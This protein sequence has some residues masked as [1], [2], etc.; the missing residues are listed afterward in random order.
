MADNVSPLFGDYTAKIN[1][2]YTTTPYRGLIH[3]ADNVV[4]EPGCVGGN[5][6]PSYNASLVMN[7]TLAADLVIVCLGV[8]YQ[9]EEEDTDRPNLGLPGMQ[10]KLL[11]DVITYTKRPVIVLVF[12][13]GPV[14]LS[15]PKYSP[16]VGALIQCF[17]PAQAT[18]E[19]LLQVLFTRPPE[20]GGARGGSRG[21][22][23]MATSPA[24]RSP[25]TWPLNLTQ[26]PEMTNYSMEGR[27]YRYFAGPGAPLYPFGYGLSYSS[28]KYSDLVIS[29]LAVK[30]GDN[31]SV[32]VNIYNLGPY[33]SD[34]VT[35]VYVSWRNAPVRMP[36]IQLVA[37]ARTLVEY[38]PASQ[39]YPL[40]LS[41]SADQLKVWDDSRGF[42]FY[43]AKIDVY[44][45][46]QQ[47]FQKDDVGS[48]IL[49]GIIQTTASV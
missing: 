31:V 11:Q 10:I 28:F 39:P 25:Y 30:E 34:E 6:C 2:T 37:M 18:G 26:I 17:Y 19:A 38:S 41:F 27:T 45:G 5:G 20:A 36:N 12:S 3:A 46:G 13:G 16:F 43:T 4:L 48:N 47:P 42:V 15:V 35:Q 33:D 9:F 1:M 49:T 44:V 40:S 32:S 8:G 23:E 29:P 22:A 24:G 14:D 21:P 7:A